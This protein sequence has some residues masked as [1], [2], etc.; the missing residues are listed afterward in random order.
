MKGLKLTVPT[1]VGASTIWLRVVKAWQTDVPG[2]AAWNNPGKFKGVVV[3][4]AWQLMHVPSG[5][6]VA[7]GLKRDDVCQI[8]D[9]L[10]GVCDWTEQ[11]PSFG[12]LKVAAL[13]IGEHETARAL[14]QYVEAA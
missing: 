8:A 6:H 10:A 4:R 2:L 1:H 7:S 13:R 14:D 5:M 9:L 12:P 3:K 11:R